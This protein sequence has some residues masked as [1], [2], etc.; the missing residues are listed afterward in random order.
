M[1]FALSP[2]SH[3]VALPTVKLAPS[4]ATANWLYPLFLSAVFAVQAG[5]PQLT[6]S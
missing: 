5:T 4:F 6:V 3:V 1:P 2:V